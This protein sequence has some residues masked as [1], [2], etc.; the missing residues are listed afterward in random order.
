[1]GNV[2]LARRSD[3]AFQK[4][5]AIKILAPTWPCPRWFTD[6]NGA[7]DSGGAGTSEHRTL[8]RRPTSLAIRFISSWSMSPG[9]RL[10]NTP[11][12]GGWPLSK[13]AWGWFRQMCDAVDHAHRRN[14][15]HRDLKPGNVLV[16][17]AGEVKLLDFGI[18]RLVEPRPG[19]VAVAD[20]RLV[21]DT[22]V[23]EPGAGAR[24]SR[25]PG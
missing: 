10:P 13:N 21:D 6:P 14:I 24:R 2:Y 11:I 12:A 25:R 22:R 5:V 4:E 7:R 8:T 20:G 17:A 15:V 23:C 3:Q 18:A 16:T 1:M 19:A 9:S